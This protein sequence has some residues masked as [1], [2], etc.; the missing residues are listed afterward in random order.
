MAALALAYCLAQFVYLQTTSLF[1]GLI[2]LI[3]RLLIC[4]AQVVVFIVD[5]VLESASVAIH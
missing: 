1:F 4:Y 3:V 2:L 5:T